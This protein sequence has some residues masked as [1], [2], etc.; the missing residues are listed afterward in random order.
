M[1]GAITLTALLLAPADTL[2]FSGAEG[3]LEVRPAFEAAPDIQVD[4][5]LDEVEWSRAAVLSGFTQYEPV[6]GIPASENTEVRV[7]YSTDAIYFG[8]RA[9]DSDPAGIL[10]RL[11]E[12][13]RV[14][15]GDDWVR[16]M[17]DTF[18]DQRQA[19]VFYVNP[20]GLQT[21]G[22]WIEGFSRG[23]G[24]GMMGGGGVSIDFNPD[25]IWESDGGVDEEGWAAE[26]R[27][28]YVSLRFR[29]VPVQTWGIQVAREVKRRGFKQS[30][31]PLTQE[32]SST[33]AQS[34][35]LVG[36]RDL[37]SKRLVEINPVVT[38]TRL[39]SVSTASGVF[40]RESPEPDFGLNGRVGLTQNLVLDGTYNP[41]F[42]QVEA[43]A[44]QLTVNERF[45]L[46]FPERRP[47]FLEG[48]EIFNTPTRLVYT[49]QIIDPLAGAKLTGKV[50]SVNMGL[51]SSLDESPSSIGG[52]QGHAAFNLFR[53]RKDI[54]R[55]STVGI[56][57]T[58][59]TA[60]SAVSPEYNRVLAGDARLVV[61]GRYTLTGQ[62]AGSVDRDSADVEGSGVRPMA[63]MQVQRSGRSF[64]WD[65]GVTDVAPGFRTRSGFVT[66]VGETEANAGITL[67]RFGRAGAVLERTS[68]RIMYN[69]F[70]IHDEF[71][72]G[73]GPYESEVELW[74]TFSFRGDRSVTFVLRN[75]YFRFQPDDYGSYALQAADGSTLPFVTP[76]PLRY[77]KAWGFMPRMRI[78]NN[79][80]VNGRAFFREVPIYREG[81]R[82]YEIQAGPDVQYRPTDQ[83]QLALNYTY[84]RIRRTDGALSETVYSTVHQPRIRVQYQ[85]N[86]S[87]FAR[88]VIQHEL[89]ERAGLT[90]PATGLPILIYGAPR[91]TV[92]TGES[93]MQF[94]LQYQPSP[95]TIFYVGFSHARAG[96]RTYRLRDMA[97]MA[98]GLFVKLSYLFRM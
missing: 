16:I 55:G 32:V 10:A 20:L 64:S 87:V 21:D 52:G 74:P 57:Y 4:G 35:R 41:D 2:I 93:M 86:K 26:I 24:F 19:Y 42:S 94:L 82:G 15:F 91:P 29:E 79:L 1:I 25:F 81:G 28:P 3:Q 9:Y 62:F 83:L 17:L 84:S 14:V 36:L 47:F 56:L 71:W 23:G 13:D 34:G 69:N 45:A 33:L 59:R 6:E 18:D 38:G 46:S 68:A 49:R 88:A 5:R 65:V 67:T 30:W 75:G 98:E 53:A 54:G 58:D 66:R 72:D 92:S 73:V 50:G 78:T 77:M 40:E 89:E 22:L 11:G 27:V 70:F 90:D 39:G 80:N 85:F 76:E 96:E 31:A 51:I 37:R 12:R 63:R 48:V 8:I 95:G 97:P 44:N 43:D 60:V 61:G 7:F